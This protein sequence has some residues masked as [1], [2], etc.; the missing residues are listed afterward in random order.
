M[1][2]V[3]KGWSWCERSSLTTKLGH[4]QG[5]MFPAD[6]LYAHL[7]GYMAPIDNLSEHRQ[8]CMYP[9]HNL[10]GGRPWY[11]TV[12]TFFLYGGRGSEPGPPFF[13]MADV[14]LNRGHLFFVWRTWF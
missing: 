10:C 8:G 7:W 12:A 6:N 9:I 13:F 5:Y 14:V 11:G 1:L 2:C 4:L 3:G